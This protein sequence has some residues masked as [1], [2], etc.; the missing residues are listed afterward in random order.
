MEPQQ[1]NIW[2][3]VAG[4]LFVGLGS[5]RVYGHFF[6]EGVDYGNFRLILAVAFIGYG[7]FR[8]YGYFNAD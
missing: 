4:I 3:L 6:S 1:K 8:L 5:Y 2:S 7:L